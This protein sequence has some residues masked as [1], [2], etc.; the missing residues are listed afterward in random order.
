MKRT[1]GNH[2]IVIDWLPLLNDLRPR[3]WSFG[4][5]MYS[6]RLVTFHHRKAY[7]V[8]ALY[9]HEDIITLYNMI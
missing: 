5:G 4:G 1:T 7:S 2:G 9:T 6:A 8:A 3:L